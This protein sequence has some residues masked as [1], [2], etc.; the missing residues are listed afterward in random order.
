LFLFLLKGCDFLEQITQMPFRKRIFKS[1]A[2]LGAEVSPFA[3][4]RENILTP[5]ASLPV[6]PLRYIV[7]TS[8]VLAN[9]T[10]GNVQILAEE[11]SQQCRTGL[12]SSRL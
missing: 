11:F 4:H 6:N 3:P 12:K 8:E 7:K 9:G 5:A 10:L 1:F 2:T